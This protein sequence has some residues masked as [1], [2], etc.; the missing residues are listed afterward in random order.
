M[1]PVLWARL[2]KYPQSTANI[3]Q[4]DSGSTDCPY[5]IV[6]P[7]VAY[8]NPDGPVSNLGILI[9]SIRHG[10]SQI[11]KSTIKVMVATIEPLE[12]VTKQQ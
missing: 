12:S 6:F 11:R 8:S 1:T 7:I 9:P 3:D 10:S 4:L 5:L 2:W